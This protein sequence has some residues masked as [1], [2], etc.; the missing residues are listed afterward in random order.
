M[1]VI[2]PGTGPVAEANVEQA[3]KNM[4]TFVADVKEKYG[5]TYVF[6]KMQVDSEDESD[7][8][9]GF[10]LRAPQAREHEVWMPGI[11]L[12]RVRYLGEPQNPWEFP[13]L[14]VDGSSWLWKF[15]VSMFE[16]GRD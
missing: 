8:R 16:P 7:G 15:A 5:I 14:Y 3:T 11:E 12:E 13:R 6:E 10:T 1:I 2:N 4:A 9:F